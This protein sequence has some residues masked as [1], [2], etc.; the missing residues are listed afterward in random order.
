M[1]DLVPAVQEN[2]EVQPLPLGV[3]HEPHRLE[4]GSLGVRHGKL[5]AGNPPL[6]P[7]RQRL[8]VEHGVPGVENPARGV[9]HG[10][11][12]VEDEPLEPENQRLEVE[13]VGLNSARRPRRVGGGALDRGDGAGLGVKAGLG[14]ASR[15]QKAD[16][17]RLFEIR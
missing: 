16:G 17:L 10:R 11:P 8:E 7:F 5:E 4:N 6:D 3:V 13:K 9:V 2:L 1:R 12:E 15:R 14:R